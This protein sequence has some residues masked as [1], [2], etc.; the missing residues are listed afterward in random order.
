[1]A[2]FKS[3]VSSDT[4]EPLGLR[5]TACLRIVSKH[6]CE[7]QD[8]QSE[9]RTQHDHCAHSHT[10]QR[11]V[12]DSKGVEIAWANCFMMSPIVA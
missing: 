11:Q 5:R 4:I 7:D 9:K 6:Q 10:L 2:A 12:A 1:M 3:G 8:D